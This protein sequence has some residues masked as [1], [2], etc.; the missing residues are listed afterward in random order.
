MK[1][2][3][4]IFVTLFFFTAGY[5]HAAPVTHENQV[6][7]DGAVAKINV[8]V[9]ADSI[10]ISESIVLT[11]EVCS[12]KG[13][14][15][16]MPSFEEYGF[17]TNF[18]ER[19]RRFRATDVSELEQRALEDGSVQYSQQFT[20]EPFLSG[21]Y[22]VLP[23]MISFFKDENP[24]GTLN[25]TSSEPDK[26]LPVFTVFAEG[27]RI[28]VNKMPE[29]RRELSDIFG[30]SD[31]HLDK[32]TKRER[33]PEDQSDAE[34]NQEEAHKLEEVKALSEKGFPW[35][36]VWVILSLGCLFPMVWF[37]GR[38]KISQMIKGSPVPAHEIAYQAFEKLKKR[39]LLQ[40]GQ[41]KTFYYELSFIL[42]IYIGN[43]FHIYAQNQTTEEFY[44]CLLKSNPFDPESENILR[45]FSNH[46]DE[47]KY[48]KYR[49]DIE[50]GE[51]SFNIAR[52]FVDKTRII[53][54]DVT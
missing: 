48:S 12:P 5:L 10:T 19:S 3:V 18:N 51:M 25:A 32:L 39:N 33:R 20:L 49:P 44:T 43:R 13:Y 16:Q 23:I 40:S 2:I 7:Y 30:Q 34:L 50:K 46:A 47:V 15:P 37:F 26:R 14:V 27:F 42:R 41:I 1:H 9:S 52:S 8:T 36:I 6:A 11:V 38:K 24:K 54:K 21:N 17:S 22:S 29:S 45:E 53:E 31:Y 28:D 35:W 4:F